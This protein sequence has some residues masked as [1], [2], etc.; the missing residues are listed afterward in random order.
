[1]DYRIGDCKYRLMIFYSI[2]A[3][4]HYIDTDD[5]EYTEIHANGAVF[6][7]PLKVAEVAAQI[8]QAQRREFFA[9]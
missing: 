7:S 5:H 8:A 1:M 2:N 3:I 9:N 4:S 6:I